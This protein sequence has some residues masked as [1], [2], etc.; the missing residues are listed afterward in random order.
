LNRPICILILVVAAGL[1]GCT[2]YQMTLTNAERSYPPTSP[3]KVQLFLQ[4][5][6]TP[7]ASEIGE[8][9]V[10][11]HSENAG[12]SYLKSRAAELGADGVINV[13]VKI[14]TRILHILFPIPIH[15]Y[16]VSGTAIRYAALSR[17][18]V[19]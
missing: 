17:E 8:I 3:E 14:Q 13:E 10:L 2:P 16:H 5:E 12:I 1:I 9:I 6:K 11:E 18:G 7:Q 19:Q 15:S 4:G